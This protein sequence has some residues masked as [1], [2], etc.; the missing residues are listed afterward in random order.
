MPELKIN[1]HTH[2]HTPD[3]CHTYNRRNGDYALNAKIY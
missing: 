3:S 2:T 1:T